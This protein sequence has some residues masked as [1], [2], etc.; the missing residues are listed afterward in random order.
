MYKTAAN[1]ACLKIS[2]AIIFGRI[3]SEKHSALP[4]H[5][6]EGTREISADPAHLL[7]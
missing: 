2:L 4:H 6:F 1:F 7:F 3:H 5:L